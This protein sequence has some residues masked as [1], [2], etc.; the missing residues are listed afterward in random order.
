MIAGLPVLALFA[1]LIPM[2]Y[3]AELFM[4]EYPP[5]IIAIPCSLAGMFVLLACPLLTFRWTVLRRRGKQRRQITFEIMLGVLTGGLYFITW[6][7]FTGMSA[8]Q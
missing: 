1:A 3:L 4:P 6:I 2:T 8:V 7:A 5:G